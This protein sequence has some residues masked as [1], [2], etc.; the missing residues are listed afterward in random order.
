MREAD[1]TNTLKY[2]YSAEEQH[3]FLHEAETRLAGAAPEV[4]PGD[5]ASEAAAAERAA[6]LARH[7]DVIDIFEAANCEALVAELAAHNLT[8]R[9]VFDQDAELFTVT[10]PIRLRSCSGWS[11]RTGRPGCASS[12]TRVSAK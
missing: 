10:T 9:N 1:G 2:L 8:P 6:E 4:I 11:V 5:P 3:A 12:G 7:F